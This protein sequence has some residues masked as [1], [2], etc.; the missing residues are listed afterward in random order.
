MWTPREAPQPTFRAGENERR[1]NCGK[2]EVN[3]FAAGRRS[4]PKREK[5]GPQQ[6]MMLKFAP[7]GLCW[8]RE[9]AI[10]R[11]EPAARRGR[12]GFRV[13][14]Y[15]RWRPSPGLASALSRPRS[16]TEDCPIGTLCGIFRD[17]ESGPD[18][19][20]WLGRALKG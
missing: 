14:G 6:L 11:R 8:Q 18:A 4:Q 1:G 15:W 10:P 12:V 7:T 2:R 20:F 5:Q 3:A 19:P 13:W 16:A 17:F 9:E